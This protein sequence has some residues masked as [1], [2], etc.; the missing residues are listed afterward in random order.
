MNRLVKTALQV[1]AYGAF[2]AFVGYLSSSPAYEYGSADMVSVK[3]SLSHA[4]S[5]VKPCVRLTP[6]EIA[7]LP[8]NMRRTEQC[9][10][11]RLPLTVELAVDGEVVIQVEAAPSGLWRDGPASVYER[12]EIEPGEHIV[13]ARLRDTDRDEGWDYE[14]T[15]QV[16]LEAG[17]YFSISFRAETGGF[18]FR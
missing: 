2:T 4:A 6:Q 11:E 13:T 17:R 3:L 12:F 10:R 5:R 9:E 1:L 16:S 7:A 18:N 14:Q 15:A 8:P